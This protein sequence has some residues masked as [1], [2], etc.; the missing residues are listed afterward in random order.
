MINM[1]HAFTYTLKIK[2]VSGKHD[3][4]LG[5]QREADVC[6][7]EASLVLKENSQDS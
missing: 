7:F 3:M 5:R 2:E 1:V 6:E 4:A